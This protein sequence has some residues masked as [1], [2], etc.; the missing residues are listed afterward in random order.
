MV[1][2]LLASKFEEMKLKPEIYTFIEENTNPDDSY[3]MFSNHN[4]GTL[5]HLDRIPSSHY[6]YLAPIAHK[7]GDKHLSNI[8]EWI[9]SNPPDILIVSELD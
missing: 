9:E 1:S 3:F 8:I 6:Y 2:T 7:G 5:M 4:G